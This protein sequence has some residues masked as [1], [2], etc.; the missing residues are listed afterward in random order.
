MK[1]ILIIMLAVSLSA[2]LLLFSQS[3]W[4][5]TTAMG[6]Y[7]EFPA[8]GYYGASNSF[9]RN[10]LIKVEN[11]ENGSSVEVMIVDRLD[12]PGLFLLLSREAAE[13]IGIQDDRIARTRI[14]LADNSSRLSVESADRPYSDDPDL[15]PN[16]ED[17]LAFLDRYLDTEEQAPAVEPE[18][19]AMAEP[20]I[21][22]PGTEE[23]EPAVSGDTDPILLSDN[24]DGLGSAL[25]EEE[26]TLED[27]VIAA[28]AVAA[29]IAVTPE[30]APVPA[31][32]EIT[33]PY[34]DNLALSGPEDD[35]L[36][37]VPAAPVILEK[38][39]TTRVADNMYNPTALEEGE[40]FAAADLPPVPEQKERDRAI[41]EL[42]PLPEPPYDGEDDVAFAAVSPA[43]I[44]DRVEKPKEE[45][46]PTAVAAVPEEETVPAAVPEGDVEISLVPAENR[47]PESSPA[48]AA[49][50]VEKELETAPE[51]EAASAPAVLFGDL[52]PASD[53][54]QLAVFSSPGSARSTAEKF[55]AT[56]PVLVLNQGNAYYKVL[57][58]PLSPDESGALLLNFKAQGFRDAFIR[59]GF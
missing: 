2:T 25:P 54:L 17:N 58:G 20:L 57:V 22:A 29:E 53:Y 40:E 14:V 44:E 11:I 59:K 34:T 50:E 38:A 4:E 31:E 41:A 5:G 45:T 47:P 51:T 13:K 8:T 16:A 37:V 30:P 42:F 55:S 9:P 6:R 27:P 12:D 21:I 49:A 24:S 10:T 19:P 3:E 1:K 48:V 33:G 43:L 26:S 7:G 36:S 15:N 39:D 46:S 18:A 52:D 56:Y 32:P 23:E 28:P 35:S